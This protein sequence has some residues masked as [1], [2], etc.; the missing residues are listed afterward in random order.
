MTVAQLQAGFLALGK[1]L[2]SAEETA[3]RRRKFKLK[4]KQSRRPVRSQR[5]A[6]SLLAA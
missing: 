3:E 4:I 5:A 1:Q 6:E 2:Y